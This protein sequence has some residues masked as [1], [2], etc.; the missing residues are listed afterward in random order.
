[1]QIKTSKPKKYLY[2]LKVLK[3]NVDIFTMARLDF[4]WRFERLE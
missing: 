4:V 2:R 1:M 3:Y